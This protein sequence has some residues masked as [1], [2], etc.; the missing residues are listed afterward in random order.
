MNIAVFAKA[1]EPGIAKTR[2]IPALGALGA[3]RLHRR[4]TRRAV[5]TAQQAHL[6]SVTVWCAPSPRHRFFRA[7]QNAGGVDCRAQLAG[8]L[9]QRML[10]AF[11][12][13]CGAGPLLL[14]G[15]DCPALRPQDLRVAAQALRDGDEAVFLP[16]ED[17]GYVLIGS[18]R[19][20]PSLF[21]GIAW[22]TG[23]VMAETRGRLRAAGITWREPTTL[24]DVDRPEDLLRLAALWRDEQ[25]QSAQP[26]PSGAAQLGARAAGNL[27]EPRRVD[28][29]ILSA[30]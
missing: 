11:R 24:W 2:L 7:L 23:S 21:E 30:R 29:P 19:P 27:V 18:R 6:G 13:Q 15:T 25:L 10:H 8:D 22:G 3:A 16:A 20:L 12:S 5:L 28:L 26:L 14:I 17:G 9:G 4:L 1:P